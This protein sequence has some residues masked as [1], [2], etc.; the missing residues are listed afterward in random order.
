MSYPNYILADMIRQVEQKKTEATDET[1]FSELLECLN[2][3]ASDLQENYEE[4]DRLESKIE[5]LESDLDSADAEIDSLKED[6]SDLE[7]ELS[8]YDK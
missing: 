6:I 3:V 1:F 5:G 8:D 2:D 4:I 7:D